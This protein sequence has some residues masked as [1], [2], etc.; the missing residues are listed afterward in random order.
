METIKVISVVVSEGFVVALEF[1]DGVMKEIDLEPY[2][3]GE[4]V[5]AI[6]DDP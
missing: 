4:V 2:L 1:S 5:E 3:S 6:H